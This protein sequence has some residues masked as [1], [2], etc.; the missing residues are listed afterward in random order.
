MP[1]KNN[2]KLKE[3]V[4]EIKEKLGRLTHTVFGNGTP[5]ISQ[6]L[7][8]NEDKTE[9]A[10]KKYDKLNNKL[11]WVIGILAMGLAENMGLLKILSSLFK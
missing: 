2:E 9:A 10:L 4:E 7:A 8:K 3:T 5:G 6:R 1:L 11:N